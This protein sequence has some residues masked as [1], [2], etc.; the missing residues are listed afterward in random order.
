VRRRLWRARCASLR[1][2]SIPASGFAAVPAAQ[3]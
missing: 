1:K 3:R 2:P